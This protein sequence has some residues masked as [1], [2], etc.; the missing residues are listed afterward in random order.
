VTVTLPVDATGGYR[1]TSY[2]GWGPFV[3]TF[4]RASQ[5]QRLEVRVWSAGNAVVSVYSASLGPQPH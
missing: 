4:G 3:A 2:G 1:P 5:T